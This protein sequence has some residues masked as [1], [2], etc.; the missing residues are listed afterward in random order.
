MWG[1]VVVRPADRYRRREENP[2]LSGGKE[3][4]K[5]MM[6]PRERGVR[7]TWSGVPS[8]RT[9]GEGVVKSDL[10]KKE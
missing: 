2:R 7:T 5:S 6:C 3:M 10:E 9:F 1:E 4:E 8:N